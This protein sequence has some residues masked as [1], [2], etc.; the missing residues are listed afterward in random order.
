MGQAWQCY[1]FQAE[2][3][4]R[5]DVGFTGAVAARTGGPEVTPANVNKSGSGGSVAL[6]SLTMFSREGFLGE[7][8]IPERS[9]GGSRLRAGGLLQ[10]GARS[11]QSGSLAPGATL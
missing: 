11:R 9:R 6:A 5:H 3:H 4:E 10:M 1:N 2:A 8:S 7:R